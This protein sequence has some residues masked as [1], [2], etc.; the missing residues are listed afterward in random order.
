MA[1]RGG[2]VYEFLGCFW[3]GC[4]KCFPLNRNMVKLQ[5]TKQSMNELFAL[6][7][8]KENYIRTLGINYHSIWEH[9]FEELLNTCQDA[10]VVCDSLDIKERL[11]PRDSFFGGRTNTTKL[12]NKVKD[13]EK[14][15]YVD[16]TSLYINKYEKYPIKHPIIIT[17][18]FKDISEYFGIA[19]VTILPPK[20]LYHP[21][22]PQKLNG[23]LT[24]A[25]C[26]TCAERCSQKPYQCPDSDW[27]MTG[28]WCTPEI[29]K[30]VEKGYKVIEIFEVYHFDESSQYDPS[31][32]EGGLFG[33]YINVF[34]KIKQESSDWPAWVQSE[35]DAAQYI[36]QYFKREGIR[37][38][39]DNIRKNKALRSLAKLL[40][41]SFWGKF[42]QRLNMPQTTYF[43]EYEADKFFQCLSDRTKIIKDFHIVTDDTIQV[44]WEN[45][46]HFILEN[47]QTNIF[48]ASMTTCWA[49]LKLY[50]ILEMLG[51][52]VLYY[53]TDSVIYVSG[54]SDLNPDLG[55]YLGELTSELDPDDHITHFVS[56]GPKQYSYI[57]YKGKENI[58]DS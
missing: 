3:Y 10:K 54:Q 7:K 24:F 22:L 27:A 19:K 32:E 46:E 12:H 17:Q 49:R 41:N 56:G 15:H 9:E 21:V 47:D 44:T 36:E 1:Q 16:F 55:D 26:R 5:R 35:E 39:P 51:N 58:F 57:T 31:T 4:S 33:E 23:K 14:V 2:T 13:D 20:G 28:T 53:D 11:D 43:H 18:G 40:L 34:L 8:K 38:N 29:N 50:G 37:L 25:L 45:D 30:A 48:V 42:G 52:R 6:T